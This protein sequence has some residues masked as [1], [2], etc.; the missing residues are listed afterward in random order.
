MV[1]YSREPTVHKETFLPT[2]WLLALLK[3]NDLRYL[4]QRGHGQHLKLGGYD[5]SRALFPA[6]KVTF[7]R[8]KRAF[9]VYCKLLGGTYSL[10]PPIPKS[11]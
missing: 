11:M 9:F 6:K 10:C 7:S 2:K 1:S 8:I 3:V 5:T 4:R